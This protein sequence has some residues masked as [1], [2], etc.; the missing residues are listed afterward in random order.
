MRDQDCCAAKPY[1]D[2][3]AVCCDGNPEP[4][5]KEKQIAREVNIQPLN[6]GFVVRVG[7]QT[8]A[9]E[10]AEKMMSHLNAYL[11]NPKKVEHLWRSG[12]LEL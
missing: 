7:C 9:F 6:H 5:Y 10:S 4:A 2:G 3:G 8:F 12:E 1:Y 11:K